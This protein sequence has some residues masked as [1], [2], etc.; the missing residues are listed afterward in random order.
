M[1][2][3]AKDPSEEQD[4]APITRAE[5]QQLMSRLDGQSKYMAKL[6]K[7]ISGKSGA[8]GRSSQAE[9]NQGDPPGLRERVDA[10]AREQEV[11]RQEREAINKAKVISQIARSLQ[12]KGV[13]PELAE[14]A[15]EVAYSRNQGKFSLGDGGDVSF[16][17]GGESLTLD[18]WSSNFV[19]SE[20][21]SAYLPVKNG[22]SK[23]TLPK[24]GNSGRRV[25]IT[26]EQLASGDYDPA[27]LKDLQVAE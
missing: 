24:G 4:N 14:D 16:E 7:L 12:K 19:A 21:G 27:A 15:A 6:E 26:P 11:I 3:P 25:T 20:K 1:P 18:A 9:T 17:H 13:R 10:L 22:P 5:F 23:V 2:D 8:E